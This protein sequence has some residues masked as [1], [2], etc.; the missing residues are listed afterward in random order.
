MHEGLFGFTRTVCACETCTDNC[1]H[2]SGVCAPQDIARWAQQHGTAFRAWALDSLAASPGA[3]ALRQGAR[4]RIP[5]IVPRRDASG[6]CH[7]LDPHDQCMIHAQ[8]PFGCAYFDCTQSWEEGNRRSI[9][10][11][12][13]IMRDWESDG[14]YSRLWRMLHDAG[15]TVEGPT[16]SRARM[17]QE[18]R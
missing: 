1:R 10:V 17:R 14:P 7:W 9:P 16:A 2:M 18:A 5:T 11:H 15:K 4:I 13:A 6:R 8:A 3:L 12:L